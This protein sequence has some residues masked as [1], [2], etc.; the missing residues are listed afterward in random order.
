[1]ISELDN[2][3][4]LVLSGEEAKIKVTTSKHV[5]YHILKRLF[6]IVFSLLGCLF[7]IPLTIFIKIAYMLSGDFHRIIF[8]QDRIGKDGKIFNESIWWT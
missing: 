3:A 7:L 2:A 1:M 4:K 8:V 5:V 6:D